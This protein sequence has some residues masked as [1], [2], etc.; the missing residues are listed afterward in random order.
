M[1]SLEGRAARPE[2]R[3]ADG[4]TA[5][6]VSSRGVQQ[7]VAHVRRRDLRADVARR[8]ARDAAA[9][10]NARAKEETT[11]KGKSSVSARSVSAARSEASRTRKRDFFVPRGLR[12]RSRASLSSDSSVQ[13]LRHRRGGRG[14]ARGDVRA[15]GE[16]AQ[17]GVAHR[18][19]APR[20]LGHRRVFHRLLAHAA[21]DGRKLERRADARR[22]EQMPNEHVHFR[23]GLRAVTRGVPR[24][25]APRGRGRAGFRERRRRPNRNDPARGYAGVRL[26]DGKA[27]KSSRAAS[28]AGDCETAA[29]AAFFASTCASM[30]KALA[31]YSARAGGA[32]A[33]R[34]TA[35]V[36]RLPRGTGLETRGRRR[37]C[38]PSSGESPPVPGTRSARRSRRRRRRRASSRCWRRPAPRA[39]PN[40]AG[41]AGRDRAPASASSARGDARP[42]PSRSGGG[43]SPG[44]ARP[45]AERSRPARRRNTRRGASLLGGAPSSSSAAEPLGHASSASS[46]FGSRVR[47]AR[48]AHRGG[49]RRDSHRSVPPP[50]E[51]NAGRAPAASRS[52]PDAFVLVGRRCAAARRRRRA[53]GASIAAAAP[54][55]R[56]RRARRPGTGPSRPRTSC[57]AIPG[58]RDA[59]GRGASRTARPEKKQGPRGRSR[60]P[61]PGTRRAPGRRRAPA[62]PRAA[63]ARSSSS[64]SAVCH[65]RTAR[66]PRGGGDPRAAARADSPGVA[67]SGGGGRRS[68]E[69]LGGRGSAQFRGFC[70]AAAAGRGRADAAASST[71]ATVLACSRIA[72]AGPRADAETCPPRSPGAPAPA[73]AS[74]PAS[75]A[76]TVSPAGRYR[77]SEEEQRG[78]LRAFGRLFPRDREEFPPRRATACL[79][80]AR[81]ASASISMRGTRARSARRTPR[82]GAR[83]EKRSAAKA[84]E[85]GLGIRRRG[86]RRYSPRRARRR[87]RGADAGPRGP[88]AAPGGG[89]P[90]WC[91]AARR[92]NAR[93]RGCPP[94]AAPPRRVSRLEGCRGKVSFRG[95]PVAV[96]TPSL[97]GLVP[98]RDGA[99]R[100]GDVR[101]RRRRHGAEQRVFAVH[102]RLRLRNPGRRATAL[103]ARAFVLRVTHR[104]TRVT[105]A[106][107]WSTSPRW[108]RTARSREGRVGHRCA[109]FASSLR[110]GRVAVSTSQLGATDT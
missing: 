54:P 43:A 45:S 8:R 42:G 50:P 39:G 91:S 58:T 77:D 7:R 97:A 41:R 65:S 103:G 74:A 75:P 11:S 10:P 17:V 90:R 64:T 16:R 104:S 9:S 63:C 51:K 62:R 61:P 56:S 26:R 106:P 89:A 92:G 33:R 81:G 98:G 22:R 20:V 66:G 60:R 67:P 24:G 30:E 85:P 21:H 48:S 32:K 78:E 107:E 59:A 94:S 5:R 79:Q 101:A 55:H 44:R 82:L 69:R 31:A 99:A 68:E 53:T 46:S 110:D 108:R 27:Q 19:A 23:A 2:T 38:P 29:A 4:A 86:R 83:L 1:K 84:R 13:H 6:E 12:P 76:Y 102:H 96:R 100:H 93:A 3:R 37:R 15:G 52:L 25:R 35:G 71:S 109:R 47:A 73:P 105:H 80:H 28:A 40:L 36:L 14:D 57:A 34:G 18:R 72:A 49:G 87:C 70:A 95:R 88:A